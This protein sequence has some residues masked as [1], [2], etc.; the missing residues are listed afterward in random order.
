MQGKDCYMRAI[1]IQEFGGRDKLQVM[2]LPAPEPAHGEVLI[3]VKAA[4][5]N[6]VDWKIRAR[7]PQGRPSP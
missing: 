4:G 7:F 2:D 1:A 6:P 3:S 5:V